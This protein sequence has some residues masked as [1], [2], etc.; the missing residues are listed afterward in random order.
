MDLSAGQ[1][2]GQGGRSLTGQSVGLG[3]RSLTIDQGGRSLTGRSVD[4]GERSLTGWSV[5]QGGCR[6]GL[7]A[8][9]G[10]GGCR[11]GLT[12]PSIGQGWSRRGPI[13]SL[14]AQG[15]RRAWRHQPRCSGLDE[16][17]RAKG[18]GSES[19]ATIREVGDTMGTQ[20]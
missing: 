13:G 4:Q 3:G 9:I 18:C 14:M 7:V 10:W 15:G 8:L 19:F 16:M 2:W 17:L 5:G 11:W 12:A 1:A 20:R 6:R